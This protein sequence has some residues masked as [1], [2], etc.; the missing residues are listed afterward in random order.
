MIEV[1]A[2]GPINAKVMAIG[3]G[4]GEQ[5]A[6]SGRPFEGRSG[7]ELQ[8]YLEAGGLSFW[9]MRITNL[10]K[11]YTPGNPSPTD[12]QIAFY[13][14]RLL[15][16][17]SITN[18]DYILAIGAYA[19]RFFLGQGVYM[20]GVHGVPHLWQGRVVIPCYHPA[21]GF[22]DDEMRAY[23]ARDY[24]MA[25]QIINGR[26]PLNIV[27][28]D[29]PDPIYLDVT[30]ADLEDIITSYDPSTTGA[31]DTEG[32]P[33]AE[34]SIQISMEEGTGYVLR[35]DQPDFRRGV[36]AILRHF[37]PLGREQESWP[38]LVVQNLMYDY[39]M[40]AGMGMD[41]F[42][43]NVFDT[44]YALYILRTEP[45]ALKVAARRW[46]GMEMEDYNEVVG[47]IGL[48][49]QLAYLACILETSWPKPDS[50]VKK[51]NDG[52]AKLYTPQPVEKR[53]TAILSD[54]YSE[55]LDKEGQR[56]DPH[57]R[58]K[59]VDP[60]LRRM[61]EKQLGPMPI[62]TLADIP[63]DNAVYYAGRDPD[64]TL[65]LYNRIRPVLEARHLLPLM[66]D[67]NQVLP[68][69]EEMQR[70]GMYASRAYFER[71]FDKM[72]EACDKLQSF[73]S[74][75]FY[76]GQPFN[77]NSPPKVAAMMR[78]RGL[79]GE[80]RSKKT[81]FMST[82][83][84]SIEHLRFVDECM[85]AIIDWREH[86]KMRDGFDKPIIT[87]LE[88]MDVSHG[89]IR[90]SINPYKV[91]SR[92][93]SSSDPN[94]TAIPVR[95]ELGLEIRE[96]FVAEEGNYLGSWDLSQIE[97]RYM[98][99]VS[100][101][102][103]LCQFLRE[104]RDVHSETAS[105]IFGI[106]LRS[107][108]N[109]DPVERFQ[110]IYADI[111]EMEHRYPSKRA[112]FGIITNIQGAGL[113]DQLRMF[114]CP[115]W[116]VDKCDALIR[117]WLKVYK[118]VDAFCKDAMKEAHATGAVRDVW[119]ME[120]PLP[121]VYSDDPKVVAE[122]E[123]AASSMKIQGGAQ[124]MIQRSM[125][126]LK[127]Y[128]RGLQQAGARVKWVLQIHDEII[129]EFQEDLWETLD[130]LVVEALTEHSLKLIVPVKAKGSYAKSWGKLKG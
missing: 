17:I 15:N 80:K 46:C 53:A 52:T 37:T 72:D 3:E 59:Q 10:N 124:G 102:P 13:T 99:H 34:W 42:D 83:K 24:W 55:K 113:Y 92:R 4:P 14:P 61:V 31:F 2:R 8:R 127:P 44:R 20:E 107:S 58:W 33:G 84:K 23:I 66:N 71:H 116:S 62:G 1:G 69:F 100:R 6:M 90:T 28:D 128:L 118:G 77:P 56:T 87:R 9:S 60:I 119:G 38:T 129:L 95:N 82:G 121:G 29:Y 112:G 25:G 27:T 103:L 50:R 19:T 97:M 86:E 76:G 41:F 36:M 30:G 111:Q 43:A 65:R 54:Y 101:D 105:R 68:I 35:K 108:T 39:E 130:P 126:W 110:E 91:V 115:G 125:I 16:E 123:R 109:P 79:E 93:I 47:P 11:E 32:I 26:I 7:K 122:A 114:G 75:R 106:S 73:I 48:E 22:Y 104:G 12:A 98:A 78:R 51:S 40:V 49:K 18:P 74:H 89:R 64:A 120:R 96:G 63:L 67:G 81:G 88:E 57:A 117:E 85:G 21:G 45:Q 5:E 94:L 70:T